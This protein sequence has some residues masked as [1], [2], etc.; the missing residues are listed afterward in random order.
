[1][2]LSVIIPTYNE[3]KHQYLEKILNQLC[4]IP[5]I[6][7]IVVDGPSAD[8][9][10][11]LVKRFPVQLIESDS[12]YRG[13]RLNLGIQHAT[14]EMI[15]LHHPHTLLQEGAIKA[16]LEIE[17]M[18]WGG[19]VHQFDYRHPLLSWDSWWSNKRVTSR[20][21]VYFDHC[22]F[23][24]GKLLKKTGPIPPVEIFDDHEL[25]HI[26]RRYAKPRLLPYKAVTSATRFKMNGI[27]KQILL[28]QF[29]KICYFFGVRPAWMHQMYNQVYTKTKP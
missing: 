20:G 24:H 25:S 29:L 18:T 6:E 14:G 8:G 1:M 10:R 5:D 4:H 21:V 16:L 26:L 12:I 9:T 27:L 17:D 28:N 22:I 7:V 2:R 3:I 15:L 13:A 19:F 23:V 11:G